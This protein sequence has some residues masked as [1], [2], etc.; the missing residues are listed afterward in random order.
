M[1]KQTGKNGNHAF[2]NIPPGDSNPHAEFPAN[3]AKGPE[4]HFY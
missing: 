3:L 2:I 4:M 1:V